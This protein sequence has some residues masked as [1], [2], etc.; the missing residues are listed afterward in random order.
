MKA[1]AAAPLLLSF[2][3]TTT[4]LGQVAEDDPIAK[5]AEETLLSMPEP[6]LGYSVTK[7]AI[8]AGEELLGFQ[9]LVT[10]EGAV[11]KVL[12]K[13]ELRD[14]SDRR[15]RVTAC[16]GYVNGLASSL[17]EA[18]FNVAASK[19]P[20]IQE[21]DFKAPVVVDLTFANGEGATI[22][23]RKWMFFTD[24]GYD[25]TVLAAD[26]DALQLLSEW[27]AKIQPASGSPSR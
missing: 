23:V 7:H 6:P 4:A 12:V 18:G 1:V 10:K 24:K 3:L 11:S 19:L 25:V 22:L 27:S 26:E 13:I 20:D 8:I 21:S 2:V 14:L 17:K 15:F 5:A 16:K 9:V